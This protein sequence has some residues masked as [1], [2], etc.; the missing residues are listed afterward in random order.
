MVGMAG[1]KVKSSNYLRYCPLC[2]KQD[3][4]Q[5]GESYWRRLPQV[6]GALYCPVHQVLYK[7]SSVVITDSRNDFLCA[8]ED[9]CDTD[10]AIDDYSSEVMELNLRYVKNASY[11]LFHNHKRKDLIFIINFY[12]DK[13]RERGLASNNGTLYL[14]KMFEAFFKY[15]PPDYLK[16]M[17]SSVDSG[18]EANW[19]KLFVRNNNKN[20]SPLRHIL[21]L[22]FL[23]VN[24]SELFEADIAIGKQIIVPKRSPRYN[25]EEQRKKW[26]KIIEENPGANRSELKRIGKGLHTWIYLND[27]EWYDQVTPRIR[28]RK[29]KANTIDWEKRD[30]ECLALTRKAVDQLLQGEGKPVRVQPSAIRRTIGAKRWFFNEKLVKTRQYISEVTEDI[31]SYRVRKIKWA[32]HEM[33]KNG[34][35]LTVYKI[36]LKAGFGGGNKEIKEIIT[37]VLQEYM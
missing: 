18:Q 10:L 5:L 29:E 11:V 21:Y 35:K 9:T 20:R 7:D 3:L 36:Q 16:I 33:V 4:E 6:P 15:Y 23:E 31:E 17:Q 37:E 26:L 8:D 2:F 34:E 27:R 30:K 32:T 12:I 28:L 1:S 14:D 25:I 24:A 19:L 22:Q 13:L